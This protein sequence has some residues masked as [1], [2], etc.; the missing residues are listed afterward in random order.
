MN[1]SWTRGLIAGLCLCLVTGFTPPRDL[2]SALSPV[3][4]AK[5]GFSYLSAAQLKELWRLTGEYALAE[6]FLKQ[7]GSPSFVERR[8]HLAAR[9]CVEAQALNRVA[10]YFRQKM[11][12]L[13]AKYVFACDSAQSKELIKATHARINAA[14]EEVRSMCR[15]CLFC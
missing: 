2:R 1:H 11:A 3:V 4:P 9:D 14:V 13:S 12:E 8:M 6:V 5:V 7:C 15:A 10:R